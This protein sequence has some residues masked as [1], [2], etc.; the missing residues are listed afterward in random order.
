M[1]ESC[2][3][4]GMPGKCNAVHEYLVAITKVTCVK[5]SYARHESMHEMKVSRHYN[6]PASLLPGNG[7]PVR[8]EWQYVHG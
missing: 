1:E 8:T 5:C 6:S 3:K 4:S 2:K 7:T